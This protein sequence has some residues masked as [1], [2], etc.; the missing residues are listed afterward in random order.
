MPKKPTASQILRQLEKL[1]TEKPGRHPGA[2]TLQDTFYA[3]VKTGPTEW[4]AR[5]GNAIQGAVK[6][7]KGLLRLD[8]VAIKKSWTKPC[9]IGYE[10]KVS[11]SDFLRGRETALCEYTKYCHKFSFVCPPDVIKIS[12]LPGDVGL[13]YYSPEHDCLFTKRRA[14]YR[15]IDLRSP[16]V[17]GMLMY[18]AMYRANVNNSATLKAG[19]NT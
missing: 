3:E 17:V 12:E 4:Q 1:H 14:M 8:A 15:E 11:R 6:T 5:R 18:L 16:E 10:I 7:N 13:I 9:F 19:E 2:P